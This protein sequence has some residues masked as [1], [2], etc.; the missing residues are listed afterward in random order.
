MTTYVKVGTTWKAVAAVWYKVGGVWK[1]TKPWYRVGG[2]WKALSK[3]IQLVAQT[4]SATISGSNPTATLRFA[5]DGYCYASTGTGGQTQR[6]QWNTSGFPATD[7]AIKL[8]RTAGTDP[9][10]GVAMGTWATFAGGDFSWTK[11]QTVVGSNNGTYT[12]SIRDKVSL[13]VLSSVGGFII[14][15]VRSS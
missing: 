5:N 12:V 1:T 2:V 10:T 6:F 4:A 14:N 15:A 9:T 3:A 8:D 7:F 11:T 13:E